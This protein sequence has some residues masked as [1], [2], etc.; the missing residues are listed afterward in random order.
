MSPAGASAN[1]QWRE[2]LETSPNEV[3]SPKGA[4]VR[5]PGA[6]VAPT[7]L[8]IA[9]VLLVQGL[10]PLAIDCRRSAAVSSIGGTLPGITKGH[11]RCNRLLSAV[12]WGEPTQAAGESM[13]AAEFRRI[14]AES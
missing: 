9:F 12:W 7:G 13:R 6:S 14:A 3:G 5:A 1:S 11:L 8:L 2:P 4:A 10:A